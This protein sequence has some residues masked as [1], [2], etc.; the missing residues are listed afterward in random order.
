MNNSSWLKILFLFIA[1]FALQ[2]SVASWI[3]IFGATPDFVI[4]FVVATAIKRG[5][6]AGCFWGF[7][8]G[9]SQDIYAPVEWLGANAISMTVIG[10]LVGQVEEKLLTL[11]KPAK[12][13]VLGFAFFVCDMIYYGVTGLSQDIITNLF[14]TQ[15]LPEF[16]YTVFIGGIIFY[17]DHG[18]DKKKHA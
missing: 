8:A 3:S 17:L 14:L 9:F 5:P 2:V 15:T 18:G 11:N 7:L 10:F 16:I 1:S 13:A 12:V 6:A 4:I